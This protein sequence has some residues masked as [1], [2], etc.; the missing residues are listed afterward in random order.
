MRKPKMVTLSWFPDE[1]AEVAQV[2]HSAALDKQGRVRDH[3]FEED[4]KSI[5]RQID[6]IDGREGS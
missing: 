1:A 2:L 4:A 6:S 3:G 5:W